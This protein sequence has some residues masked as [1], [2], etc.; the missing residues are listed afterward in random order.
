MTCMMRGWEEFETVTDRILGGHEEDI[1]P[2]NCFTYTITKSVQLF[3]V[4]CCLQ[5]FPAGPQSPSTLHISLTHTHPLRLAPYLLPMSQ[6]ANFG[7]QLVSTH[8]R[9]DRTC[10]PGRDHKL[11]L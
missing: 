4:R 10:K 5:K 7:R 11:D 3:Q 1:D 2:T 8:L 6:R 9:W